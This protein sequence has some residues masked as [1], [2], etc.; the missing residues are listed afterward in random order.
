MESAGACLT[1]LVDTLYA[2]DQQHA[3]AK[4]G[5]IYDQV[6]Q[7]AAQVPPGSRGLL[8]LPWPAGERCPFINPYVR[9]GF[10]NLA[11]DHTRAH[12]ARSVLEGVA[13]NTR[14]VQ[15]IFATLG[16]PVTTLNVCG[17]GARSPL[18]LQIFA[19]VLNVPLRRMT[20]LQDA[21][22]IGVALVAAVALNVFKSFPALEDLFTFDQEFRPDAGCAATYNR[23]YKVF[24]E[25]FDPYSG[26]CYQLNATPP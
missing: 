7:A 17:G 22:S 5:D 23:L 24:R 12:L 4:G 13:Y 2:A 9:A 3:K 1:W 21:G 26:L 15:D 18:W 19:D 8:Y 11:L 14:W 16:H 25:H 6:L 20:T 10:I